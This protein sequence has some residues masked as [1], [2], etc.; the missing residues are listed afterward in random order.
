MSKDQ[1]TTLLHIL[2]A[3]AMLVVFHFLPWNQIPGLSARGV[4]ILKLLCY[5]IPYLTVGHEVLLE[6][7]HNIKEGEFFDEA[8]LMML[9]TVGALIIGEYPEATAVM[10]FY[11][12]GE[13]FADVA[14]DR[15]RQSIEALMDILPQ[16]AIVL[17]DGQEIEVKPEEVQP[18]E[19]VLV[20]PGEK[21]PLDGNVI[22][23]T[24][25]LNTA[26]LTG[27]SLP[28]DISVG[29]H[30][31]SGSINL[32]SAIKVRATSTYQDSAV[33]QILDM[34][35]NSADAKSHSEKFITRF[36]HW[37][38]PIVVIGAVLLALGFAIFSDLG[39]RA[40]LCRGLV[41]LV[42]SCPCALVVSVPLTFFGGIGAASRRGILIKGSHH[43]ETLAR[44]DALV[45]DKTGTLTEGA[46]TVE[47]VYPSAKELVPEQLLE[48]AAIAEQHSHHPVA[49]S[50]TRAYHGTVD[51]ARLGQADEIAGAGLRAIVDGVTYYVGNAKLMEDVRAVYEDPQR[52]GTIVHVARAANADS[53]NS[54]TDASGNDNASTQGA[55]YLGYI[56][57][58][59]Q[60]KEDSVSALKAL[61]EAGIAKIVMLTG[62]N[63][64]V[65]AEVAAKVGLSE[66]YAGL[67]PG[68]KVTRLQSV[69]Q[70][71]KAVA[72]A[73]DGINDAPVLIA[74]DLG[75]AMGALGSDIAIESADLVLLDDHLTRIPEAIR[76]ARRTMCI[77]KE[78]IV[79]SLL[80]KVV[81]LALGAFG[82]SSMRLAIF[83]DVGV[84][85]LAVAN[86]LRALKTK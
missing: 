63:E 31:L 4:T 52:A 19:I 46:F 32:T 1:K 29:S 23:G 83:G 57:I 84:L 86:A 2:A 18:G 56:V 66:F 49:A 24:S 30:V 85:I 42:V 44:L 37:Y 61:R 11:E 76:L 72:F 10:L 75:I 68:D 48:I 54:I 8:F 14:V 6:S 40:S 43:L 41:F 7:A 27:E 79:L 9:A 17:R 59:D 64:Q 13:L 15:S 12:L 33:A 3:A 53:N 16:E 77:V 28:V 38:T 5:L 47:G 62:D 80:V 70:T 45:L 74:A 81:I 26:T 69:R 82:L 60:I 71:A 51:P 67:L 39:I 78:N 55:T 58:S 73:G 65:A 21:L 50:I 20:R 22:E 25:A 34:V 35:E 36:A